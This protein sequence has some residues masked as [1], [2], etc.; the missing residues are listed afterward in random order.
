MPPL[1]GAFGAYLRGGRPHLPQLPG[2]DEVA[3]GDQ[4]AREHRPLPRGGGWNR[5]ERT[6]PGQGRDSVPALASGVVGAAGGP[7]EQP[8]EGWVDSRIAFVLPTLLVS[9]THTAT[10]PT[11]RSLLEGWTCGL[12]LPFDVGASQR[13]EAAS[14]RSSPDVPHCVAGRREHELLNVLEQSGVTRWNHDAPRD[15]VLRDHDGAFPI[16]SPA[17]SGGPVRPH[18]PAACRSTPRPPP[19]PPSA[20]AACRVYS[21]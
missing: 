12:D 10:S 2:A 17:G 4:G 21:C 19:P 11:P 14:R 20:T 15:T 6:A 13:A 18:V 3:R 16:V 5:P 9:R 1:G 7:P 8:R